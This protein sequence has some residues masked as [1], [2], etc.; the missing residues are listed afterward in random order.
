MLLSASQFQLNAPTDLFVKQLYV[1]LDATGMTYA[2]MSVTKYSDFKAQAQTEIAGNQKT[3][4]A[5]LLATR[6]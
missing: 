1:L 5:N 3:E 6:S 2:V 4:Y